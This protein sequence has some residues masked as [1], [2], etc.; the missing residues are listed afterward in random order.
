MVRLIITIDTEEDNWGEYRSNAF[1]LEN[2]KKIPTLQRIFEQFEVRP[3]YLINYPVASDSNSVSILREC[4]KSCESEIGTH[5]H[6]WNTPPFIETL[7]AHNSM[8]CNLAP[9]LQYEKMKYLT[10][11]LEKAFQIRPKSFR[12]GRWGYDIDVAKN[13]K[14]LGYL[15]DSSISPTINWEG[16]DGPDFSNVLPFPY[17]FEVDDVFR[18]VPNGDMFEIPAT[19]GYLQK[20]YGICNFI[21]R[22]LDKEPLKTVRLKRIFSRLRILNKVWLSPEESTAEEMI[23]L[24]KAMI[25]N[26]LEV[27]NLF[28]HSTSLKAGLSPYVR[29]E[30][31]EEIFINR[32]AR[33]LVFSQEAGFV[34]ATLSEAC[35]SCVS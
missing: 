3:T 28:F 29:S 32:I 25:A 35:E 17:R 22:L 26:G 4:I 30:K 9:E 31:D 11:T 1:S 23:E 13:L 18:N 10:D 33:F 16:I 21:D 15:I 2:I 5:I 14:K 34:S 27:L 8:I 12:S 20:N 24:S 6:P 7:S 19:V